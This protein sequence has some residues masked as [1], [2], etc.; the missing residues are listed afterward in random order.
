LLDFL[1]DQ[2]AFRRRFRIL[3][4]VDDVTSA[5]KRNIGRGSD[6]R[7]MNVQWQVRRARRTQINA[8]REL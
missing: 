8:D 5:E 6:R 4:V 3:S 7:W 2:F 1:H